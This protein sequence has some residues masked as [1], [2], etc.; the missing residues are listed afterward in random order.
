M[1][2]PVMGETIFITIP[3]CY[4]EKETSTG[5]TVSRYT[6]ISEW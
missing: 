3:E 6:E 4:A 1:N 5:L 2:N